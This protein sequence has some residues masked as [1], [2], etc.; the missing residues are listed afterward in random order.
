MTLTQLPIISFAQLD[1]E[2]ERTRLRKAASDVGFFYLVDHGLATEQL[3]QVLAVSRQF[4]ALPDA[5]KRALD[6]EN[7][8]HFRGY[9]GVGAEQ[10]AGA[11]DTREQ[12][13]WMNET[14]ALDNPQQPWQRLIGPNQWPQ[15]L[16]QLRQQLLA[17]TAKQTQ[18]AVGL[19]RALCQSL[20]VDAHA[21]DHTFSD[22]P[23]THAKIIKYPG[24]EGATQGVGA[25]KDPGYLTFVLQDQQS[26]LEVEHDGEWLSVEPLA[27]SFVVNIGELLELASDGFLQA[28]KHRVRVPKPGTYRYSAAYFMAAQLDA[29]VPVLDLPAEMKA[30]SQGVS[31]DPNNPL[32]RQVGENVIKGRVRSHP[33]VA[34]AHGY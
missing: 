29:E 13:D 26:G 7:S 11:A 18:V 8:P 30:R 27:G 19:L 3:Q 34:A 6:M 9:N 15:S 28:T 2:Q 21:L 32:L 17:L 12:F 5:Q 24:V 33:N 1:T 31:T 14:T 20:G 10:T 22:A 16:P 25:H 23:Y 4:F